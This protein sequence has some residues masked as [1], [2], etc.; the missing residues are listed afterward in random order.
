MTKVIASLKQSHSAI[1]LIEPSLARKNLK[2]TDCTT[3]HKKN[4]YYLDVAETH[5]QI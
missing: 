5:F 3:I 2:M 1:S 4:Y